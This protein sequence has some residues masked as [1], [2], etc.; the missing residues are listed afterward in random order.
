MTAVKTQEI[1]ALRERL[2]GEAY[3]DDEWL[4]QF[5]LVAK[6]IGSLVPKDSMLLEVGCGIGFLSTCLEC[7]YAGIDPIEHKDLRPGFDFKVGL[8]EDIPHPDKSFDVILIKDAVNYFA[9]LGPFLEDSARVLN[10]DGIL[11]VTE[12]VGRK[13]HPVK[14]RLKNIIK[15]YLHVGMNMWNK[16]YLNF[17]TSHDIIRTAS[18]YGFSVEYRY[19]KADL[20]YYLVLRRGNPIRNPSAVCGTAVFS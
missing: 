9:D 2:T 19:S 17:Y 13:Y 8:G 18:L 1:E 3:Y 10:G 15:R 5:A 7:Q 20:R 6:W 4:R 12:Y 14:Q 16:T 11:L